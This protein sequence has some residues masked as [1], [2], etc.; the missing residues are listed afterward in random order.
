MLAVTLCGHV[1]VVAV[2][3]V[4]VVVGI[5]QSREEKESDRLRL[6]RQR[7]VYRI[8]LGKRVA[9]PPLLVVVIIHFVSI[10]SSSWVLLFISF[11][12]ERFQMLCTGF[13]YFGRLNHLATTVPTVPLISFTIVV[14]ISAQL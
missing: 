2:V 11:C 4:V 1:V 9:F 8:L 12:R 5:F 13:L 3:V 6:V 14:R 7:F 10:C